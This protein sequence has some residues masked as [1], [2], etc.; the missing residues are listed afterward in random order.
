[1]S[2]GSRWYVKLCVCVCVCVCAC[3]RACIHTP[4]PQARNNLVDLDK[5]TFSKKDPN[6]VTLIFRPSDGGK[7]WGM[8]YVVDSGQRAALLDAIRDTLDKVNARQGLS[9]G[10]TAPK[11][12][13]D[14]TG[15]KE[16]QGNV[17]QEQ[18]TNTVQDGAFGGIGGEGRDAKVLQNGGE[19]HV[20]EDDD[21][22]AGGI[23]SDANERK[24]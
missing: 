9:R 13:Q 4:V 23:A 21:E 18:G 10:E 11:D 5:V 19:T 1:M 15:A 6:L 24:R 12:E 16:G 3:V 14:R 17:S 7:P 8:L 2:V 20:I 22:G